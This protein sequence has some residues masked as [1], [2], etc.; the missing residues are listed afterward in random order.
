MSKSVTLNWEKVLDSRSLDSSID[1]LRENGGLYIWIFKGK[2]RRV[3]YVG[4]A[5]N[6]EKRFAIHF[7]SILTG[8]WNTYK[9]DEGDD[10]VN[11]LYDHYHEKYQE[12][13]KAERKC[14]IPSQPSKP[15][16]NFEE[17]FFD[18]DLLEMHRNYLSQLLF[19]FATSK[20]FEDTKIR[21]QVEGILIAGLRKL[22]AKYAGV[23]L[24]R[25]SE[26]RSYNI[27]IGNI[28]LNPK[29]SF[30]LRHEGGELQKIPEDILKIAGYDL[31]KKEV[32][33]SE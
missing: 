9:M 25:S 28:S 1:F 8:R 14:Y 10:F 13:I 19:A 20:E 24:L 11:Y 17:T 30:S 32:K 21:K 27:P 33:L 5:T 18:E 26:S 22:Y 31:K 12:Q 7:S 3:T 15:D 4:E 16:F 23:E 6:F 29:E 2:P